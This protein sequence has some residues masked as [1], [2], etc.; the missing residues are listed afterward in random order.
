MLQGQNS[1][2]GAPTRKNQPQPQQQQ[3]HQQPQQQPQRQTQQLPQQPMQ[4]V[5]QRKP[6]QQ[7][8]QQQRPEQPTAWSTVARRNANP[9]NVEDFPELPS[10]AIAP[11]KPK[12]V[13]K[14]RRPAVI[15][16]GEGKKIGELN[17]MLRG[18]LGDLGKLV[19]DVRMSSSGD[20][21]VETE[22]TL[23]AQRI[24]AA[25]ARSGRPSAETKE[26]ALRL[27]VS[28][29]DA[30]MTDGEIREEMAGSELEVIA[31]KL[32][33]TNRSGGRMIWLDVKDTKT[34]RAVLTKGTVRIGFLACPVRAF[35]NNNMCFKCRQEGHT[36]YNCQSE[37]DLR[38]CCW[39]CRKEGHLASEC[40]EPV[41]SSGAAES[42]TTARLE[43]DEET[44]VEI[45]Q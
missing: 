15:V 42:T 11:K 2:A 20:L 34:A 26:P 6:E 28:R 16:K 45:I 39:R 24:Q 30:G 10:K 3:Q 18:A 41:P 31:V 9:R 19:A 43:D 4:P 13:G 1:S 5:P 25:L 14:P 29:V 22:T 37:T 7:P 32:I 38:R 27:V 17:K 40:T 12:G 33:P 21:V 44:D 8:Q 23:S 35:V 36:Q